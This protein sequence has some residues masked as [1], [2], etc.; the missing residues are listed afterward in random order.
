MRSKVLAGCLGFLVVLFLFVANIGYATNLDSQQTDN[1]PQVASQNTFTPKSGVFADG[2]DLLLGR[3]SIY[4]EY[5]FHPHMAAF[6]N[7]II[8]K[9]TVDNYDVS[10]YGTKIGGLVFKNANTFRGWFLQGD[11]GIAFETVKETTYNWKG[12][13]NLTW[14]E[15]MIGYRWGFGEEKRWTIDFALG[16]AFFFNRTCQLKDSNGNVVD[17]VD[18]MM[19][20]IFPT[21]RLS[22][23]YLF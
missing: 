20:P 21:G 12:D 11:W 6:I 9:T 15:G 2:I 3:Y 16:L 8:L 14:V 5:Y 7:P 18:V 1:F 10:G 4:G 17:E 13:I 19:L 23:G 22:I